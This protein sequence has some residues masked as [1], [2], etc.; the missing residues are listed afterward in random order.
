MPS[1][2]RWLLERVDDR[3]VSHALYGGGIRSWGTLLEEV[4]ER[5]RTVVTALATGALVASA[6]AFVSAADAH[7]RHD[8][9]GYDH[10]S[11]R[12]V[13]DGLNGPRGLAEKYGRLVVSETDGTF[14][15]IV[16]RRHGKAHLIKLGRVRTDFAPA[17]DIGRDG[18]VWILTGGGELRTSA[19]LFKWRR[20]YHRPRPV[21]NIGRY[22]A[23]DTDPYDTEN[24][25]SD[26]NPF[27]VAALRDGSVLVADAGN[28]DLL[29]VSH[30]GRHIETVARFK[31][32]TMPMPAGFPA[33]IT[34]E[35]GQEETLPPAGTPIPPRRFPPR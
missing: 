25:P 20:G 8:G 31:T 7:Q 29:R 15:L 24:D 5:R 17:V 34:G 21:A 35:D 4:G 14:S 30:H 13:V 18:T 1:G 10:T 32:R 22:Q 6:P 26:S 27:G 23:K 28:N 12:T 2:P 19:K 9:R 16:Q 33:T 11:V 3:L